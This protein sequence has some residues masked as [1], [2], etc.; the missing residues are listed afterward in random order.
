MTRV[1][2]A[3]FDC[4]C[5]TMRGPAHR[6]KEKRFAADGRRGSGCKKQGSFLEAM[7]KYYR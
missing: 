3:V 2:L 1:Y 5:A 6:G 4:F 7:E